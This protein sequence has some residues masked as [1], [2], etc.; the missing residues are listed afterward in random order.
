MTVNKIAAIHR[1]LN[2]RKLLTRRDT[3][4]RQIQIQPTSLDVDYRPS[5]VLAVPRLV[6]ARLLKRLR[7]DS[8]KREWARSGGPGNSLVWE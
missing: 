7:V 4:A 2:Q 3:S 6:P 5:E 1:R 8:G